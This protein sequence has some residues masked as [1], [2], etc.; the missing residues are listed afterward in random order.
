MSKASLPRMMAA[1]GTVHAIRGTYS[2]TSLTLTWDQVDKGEGNAQNGNENFISEW[3]KNRSK[4]GGL[5][6]EVPGYISVNL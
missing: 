4:H 2:M 1:K 6:F 3:I 5:A